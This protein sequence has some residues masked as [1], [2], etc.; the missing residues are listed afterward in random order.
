K[1]AQKQKT[2]INMKSSFLFLS[3]FTLIFIAC[4][5]DP[6]P[7]PLENSYD[8][9]VLIVNEGNFFSGDGE[10]S[11]FDPLSGEVT[12]NLFQQSNGIILAA[13]IERLRVYGEHV[14][15]IDSQQGAPKLLIVDPATFIE[16]GRVTGL[17]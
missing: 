3:F 14:L 15:I 8:H 16:K 9:G 12:N 6:E 11:H 4:T 10:I 2:I 1:T 13:Y 7:L 5:E 17:E